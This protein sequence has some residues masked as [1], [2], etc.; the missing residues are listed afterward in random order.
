MQDSWELLLKENDDVICDA[1][2]HGKTKSIA[3]GIE[4]LKAKGKE[5]GEKENLS[6]FQVLSQVKSHSPELETNSLKHARN[7][8]GVT[9]SDGKEVARPWK[10]R[11]RF[12]PGLIDTHTMNDGLS[13]NDGNDKKRW[14]AVC[15]QPRSILK[16]KVPGSG[17]KQMSTHGPTPAYITPPNALDL[18]LL[19]NQVC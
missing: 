11:V 14:D 9:L 8:V 19:C 1:P 16:K 12:K 17:N 10:R 2:M 4:P 7:E 5:I 15:T 6:K 3:S 13:E 18:L